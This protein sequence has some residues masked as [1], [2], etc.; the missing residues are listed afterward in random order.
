MT[1]TRDHDWYSFI[2]A[3]PVFQAAK[4]VFCYREEGCV[5]ALRCVRSY[6]PEIFLGLEIFASISH[7]IEHGYTGVLRLEKCS[8]DDVLMIRRRDVFRFDV[9]GDY[10]LGV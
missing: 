6:T 1:A 10:S 7:E 2:M 5:A 3:A 8:G 4:S 9:M